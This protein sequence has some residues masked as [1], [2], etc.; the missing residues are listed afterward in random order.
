MPS[1]VLQIQS[2]VLAQIPWANTPM[3]WWLLAAG[4]PFLIHLLSRTR[5]QETDWAAMRFLEAAWKRHARRLAIEQWLVMV[6]RGLLLAVVALALADPRWLFN[7]QEIGHKRPPVHWMLVLDGTASMDAMLLGESRFEAA[8]KLA[9]QVIDLGAEG[10]TYSL[11]LLSDPPLVLIDEPTFEA[12]LV[13]EAIRNVRRRDTGGH[14]ASMLELIQGVQLD[15]QRVD[16]ERRETR[17]CFFTD[18]ASTTWA[19]IESPECQ[20][21]VAALATEA[22]FQIYEVSDVA[23]PNDVA[24]VAARLRD[25]RLLI[26][27]KISLDVTLRKMA[28]NATARRLRVLI[29]GEA[30][31]EATIAIVGTEV[32]HRIDLDIHQVGEHVIELRC[33][34]DTIPVNDRFAFQITLRDRLRVLILEGRPQIGA[35]LELAFDPDRQQNPLVVTRVPLREFRNQKLSDFDAVFLADVS[36]LETIERRMLADYMDAGGGVVWT[37]GPNVDIPRL[38][39]S[40]QQVVTGDTLQFEGVAPRGQYRFDAGEYLHPIL[41]AF[42]GQPRSGLSTTPI[43]QYLRVSPGDDA[44]TVLSLND[45]NGAIFSGAVGAGRWVFV[46]LPWGEARDTGKERWSE[47]TVWPV[48]VPI[49]H[50]TLDWAMRRTHAQR[51]VTVGEP[52]RF[53][54]LDRA[55][56]EV[57]DPLGERHVV[58]RG[59]EASLVFDGTTFAGAY[60]LVVGEAEWLAHANVDAAETRLE[61][62]DTEL[63]PKVI[64]TDGEWAEDVVISESNTRL[65]LYRF[66]FATA[67]LLLCAESWL[68]HRRRASND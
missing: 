60:R 68:T 16:D 36:S 19:N 34:D 18:L 7:S 31:P 24:I 57:I 11:F 20:R 38:Q 48:F 56:A 17:I 10:D 54:K 1:L 63:L 9:D 44:T 6:M 29:D 33:D 53:P 65:P 12:D 40:W 66:L 3:L 51:T 43:Y 23:E 25:E 45:G 42:A 50:E 67:L 41:S 22:T 21:R 37:V 46:T 61:R 55:S 64:R 39:E 5:F 30:G 26:D 62:Y 8:K 58:V 52:L 4:L 14:L 35:R 59:A 15:A 47:V 32:R 13:R 28:G 27:E 49:V 2:S